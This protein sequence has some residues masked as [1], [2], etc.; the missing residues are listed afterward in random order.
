MNYHIFYLLAR[1]RRE[2][3]ALITHFKKKGI[4]ATF[5]YV[6]LHSSPFS[7]SNGWDCNL[8]ITDDVAGRIVRLPMFNALKTTEQ[9]EVI[10]AALEFYR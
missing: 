8:P 5:H 2:R 1:D 3:D 9:D 10:E 6:P 4:L 7:R